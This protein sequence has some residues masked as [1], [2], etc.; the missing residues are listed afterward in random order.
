MI[1]ELLK[2][3]YQCFLRLLV[4]L[5]WARLILLFLT[6]VFVIFKIRIFSEKY[7]YGIGLCT[8]LFIIFFIHKNRRDLLFLNISLRNKT[9]Y[10]WIEYSL[11]CTFLGVLLFTKTFLFFTIPI[12]AYLIAITPSFS[13]KNTIIANTYVGTNLFEW[14]NGIR[15]T[16]YLYLVTLVIIVLGIFQ[17]NVIII[18]SGITLLG[19][20]ISGYYSLAEDKDMILSEIIKPNIFLR[21]KISNALLYQNLTLLPFILISFFCK[22]IQL[23]FFHYSMQLLVDLLL[24]SMITIGFIV[25]KYAFYP[26][27][28]II[29]LSQSLFVGII[30]VSISSPLLLLLASLILLKMWFMG[31]D[32]LK[33]YLPC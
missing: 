13:T 16:K 6:F 2:I 10:L 28:L 19:L 14:T 20:F 25:I 32:N 5:G 12:I 33:F 31:K 26:N 29:Q 30:F 1:V 17:N 21:K 9:T 23:N 15:Q 4:E 7:H 3:R 24:L 8:L 27:K 22:D 11:I 18:I